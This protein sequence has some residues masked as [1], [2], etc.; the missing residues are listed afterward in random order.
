MAWNYEN[1]PNVERAV[2]R[3]A[4][5]KFVYFQNPLAI[6]RTLNPHVR[7]AVLSL[8]SVLLRRG[9]PMNRRMAF[10]LCWL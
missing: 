4:T 6:M 8:S 3:F 1:N 5:C 7:L 2:R 9:R 10:D